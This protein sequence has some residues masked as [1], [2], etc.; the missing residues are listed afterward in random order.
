MKN[1][2][3]IIN[4]YVQIKHIFAEKNKAVDCYSKK[5][6]LFLRSL[7]IDEYEVSRTRKKTQK[8]RVLPDRRASVW[9]SVMAQPLNWK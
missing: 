8:D 9:T 2:L 5:K 7:I 3:K 1:I 6:A 4:C